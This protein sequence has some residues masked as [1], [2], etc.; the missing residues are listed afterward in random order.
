MLQLNLKLVSGTIAYFLPANVGLITVKI[1]I[2]AICFF[3]IGSQ[4][5]NVFSAFH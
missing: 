1:E 5:I 4:H 2:V 3:G